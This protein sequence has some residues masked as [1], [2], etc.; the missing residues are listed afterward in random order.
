MNPVKWLRQS[1]LSGDLALTLSPFW[2]CGALA[3]WLLRA[4]LASGLMVGHGC[5]V[6][7]LRCG[8]AMDAIVFA[9]GAVLNPGSAVEAHLHV[10]LQ[11]PGPAGA[12]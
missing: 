1:P 9:L 8:E 6:C 7:R 10:H 4:L 5:R 12:P 2:A 11:R 3:P